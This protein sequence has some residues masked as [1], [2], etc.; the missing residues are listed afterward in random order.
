MATSL[1]SRTWVITLVLAFLFLNS[2]AQNISNYA[3]SA[4]AA[5]YTQI[6][7]TFPTAIGSATGHNYTFPNIPI[8]F[9]FWY[10]GTRHTTVSASVKGWFTFGSTIGGS[11]PTNNLVSGGTRPVIAP[12]WDDIARIPGI[13]GLIAP[14]TFSYTNSGT[15][16]NRTLT[17][18]WHLMRWDL[19]APAT[20]TIGGDVI[21][22]QAVLYEA[23]GNIEFIYRPE[24]Q[25]VNNGSASVGIT[26]S[27]SGSGSFI[28]ISSISAAAPTMSF[29]SETNNISAKP[30]ANRRFV[31]DPTEVVAPTNLT[32][33]NI[34]AS[35]VTLNWVDNSGTNEIG[36]V[37]YRSTDNVNFTYVATTPA[38]ATSYNVTG[39]SANATSYYRVYALRENLSAPVSA[40][41]ATCQGFSLTS[42]PTG[43]I[44]ANYRFDSNAND[45][46]GLN[47]GTLQGTPSPTTNRFGMAASA[48]QFNGS[49]QYV[50]TNN[51]STN[52]SVFTV[53][54]WFKTT[55]AGGKLIG[56]GSSQ[57]GFSTSADRHIYMANDGKI[58]F[59]A[60]PGGVYRTAASTASYNDGNW[61]MATATMSAAG[62]ILYVDGVQVGINALATS[63]E[64]YTGYWRIGYDN[65][66]GWLSTPTNRFFTGDL[67]DAYIYTRALSAA[68]ITTLYNAGNGVSNNGPVCAATSV[69]L[70]ANNISGA[71]YSWT[72]PNG[73]TSTLRTPSFTYS[74][75]AKGTYT[76][77]VTSGG[78]SDIASTVVA[79]T[80]EGRWTGNVDANWSTANNW[81]NGI[82]PT[83]AVNVSIPTA[84]VANNPTLSAV[85]SSNNISVESGRILTIANGGNL[86]VAGAVTNAGSIVATAGKVTFNGTSA[87][88]IPSNVFST[89]TI[90]DLEMNNAAGVTLNGALRLTG[91]LTATVGTFNANGNLTLASSLSS[92]AQVAPINTAVSSIQGQVKVERFV[93]GGAMNPFRTTRMFSSPVYDNTTTFTNTGTR[94]A[95]FAQLIDDIIV[96]GFSGAINGFDSSNNNEASAWT[97]LSGFIPISNINTVA[98]AGRGMYAYFRGN[99]N[100]FVQKINTPYIDP[101][102]T[103]IDFDGVLNQGDISLTLNAGNHFL[104]NPYAATIDWESANWGVD[105]GSFST[106]LW[107]W[108]P[109]TRSYATYS[110]GVS[111]LGGSRYIAS[112]QSFFAQSSASGTIKFKESIKAATQQP[113]TLLMSIGERKLDVA[114]ATNLEV[115]QVENSLLRINMKPIGSFGE[116]EAVIAFKEGANPG[117]TLEDALHIDGEVVN[118]SSVVGTRRLAINFLPAPTDNVLEI[119]LNVS[120]ATTG[121]Y[122]LQFNLDQYDLGRALQLKDNY[123]QK[124]IPIV[125]G[126]IN[127]FNIDRNQASSYGA[128][129]FS[130]IV[131]PPAVLPVVL[132]SFL[133]KKQNDGVLLSWV[134][135]SEVNHK[136]FKLYR[137]GDAGNYVL[138][139]DFLPRE[140][141]KYTY[142]D[143]VPL[144]GFNYYK[145]V[146]V[147][148]NGVETEIDPI[149]IDFNVR[150]LHGVGI[151]PNPVKDKFTVKVADISSEKLKLSLYDLTGSELKAHEV[152]KAELVKGYEVDVLGLVQGVFFVKI[153]E[154]GTIRIVGVYKVMKR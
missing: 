19:N 124:I 77:V 130:V 95:K 120:A 91:I 48:Y 69:T 56:F 38:N 3:V 146:Q 97:Y 53:S 50:S 98:S 13:L 82:V 92:T 15:A 46:Y 8:G 52:P 112:G 132:L 80:G 88:V 99:R 108:N 134:T 148:L 136:S 72:G 74:D 7:G 59:G 116:D 103:V 22:C 10:M 11:I 154:V 43:S 78:C 106:A 33:T 5:T 141:G 16:P 93:R 126:S 18:Q 4:G 37:V 71:T 142:L 58:I 34:G 64:N 2:K 111:T 63:G 55:V 104:G 29:T 140:G 133:A 94:S 1:L 67:D 31:F 39:L 115:A 149:S 26:G 96:T 23:T 117:Y 44:G 65:M 119:P 49:S 109:A 12:L 113:P 152:S 27:S 75:A 9:N 127:N 30:S 129:R 125:A 81:C 24:G 85:G 145:L 102:D 107:I 61:H 128:G 79:S 14:G 137:A 100:N 54:I 51:S 153:E 122:S 143:A 17:L 68:E 25:E 110:S 131:T 138:L 21:S 84:N 135:S 73:F 62:I 40:S 101:E 83:S 76:V 36:F 47:N 86:Q 87:Q 57:T 35:S 151:Y 114:N 139:N 70:T 150:S 45:H 121:S 42:I 123:L 147:D 28:S 32:F 66:D 144:S 20:L 41:V 89:N 105:K 118:V 60:K 6:G 90:K